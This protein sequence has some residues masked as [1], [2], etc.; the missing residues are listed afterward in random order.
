ML[1]IVQQRICYFF[2]LSGINENNSESSQLINIYH[3]FLR[4][5]YLNL[6][7]NMQ[8]GQNLV[9]TSSSSSSGS[10]AAWRTFKGRLY[11]RLHDKRIAE[12]DLNGFVNLAYLF[13][14]LVKCFNSPSLAISQLKFEQL[15]NFFR[16]SNIFIKSKNLEK[17]ESILSLNS[18]SST[19]KSNAVKTIMNIKFTALRL[20][21][22]TNELTNG[23]GENLNSEE[24]DAIIK[25]DFLGT[26]NGWLEEA[27]SSAG[28]DFKSANQNSNQI[29]R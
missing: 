24:I 13:F 8:S 11:T 4:Y 25:E 9:S 1:K 28:N 3:L 19:N 10:S 18:S 27:K 17:I 26:I 14:T 29:A 20:W 5:L 6:K 16:I 7:D 23:S 15:E 21:F 12:L 22:D 2:E